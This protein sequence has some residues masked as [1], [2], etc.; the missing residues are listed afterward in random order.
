MYEF[1]FIVELT[2][3]LEFGAG[4]GVDEKL[5]PWAF[6]LISGRLLRTHP[7]LEQNQFE[8]YAEQ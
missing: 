1:G 2:F 4:Q 3:E 5:L 6:K 7:R 8:G